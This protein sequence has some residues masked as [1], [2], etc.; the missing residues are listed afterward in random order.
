ME[1]NI[2]KIEEYIRN[3]QKDMYKFAYSYVK[4]R[5]DALD[6]VQESVYSALKNADKLNDSSAVK[7][8]VFTIIRNTSLN[9]FRKNKK[10]KLTDKLDEKS[11]QVIDISKKI[12]LKDALSKLDVKQRELIILRF[13]EGFQFNEMAEMLDV[14]INTLKSRF[15]KTLDKL[16]IEYNKEVSNG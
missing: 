12:D 16:K 15:Y 2:I 9:F 10:E 6:I 7:S 8:W 4:N 3:N 11:S 1:D 14:N 5:T 13:F